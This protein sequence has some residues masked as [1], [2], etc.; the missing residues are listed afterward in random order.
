M[1]FGFTRLDAHGHVARLNALAEQS[2]TLI[3]GLRPV[4]QRISLSCHTPCRIVIGGRD[5]ARA[6]QQLKPSAQTFAL[7][8]VCV[9]IIG[10]G[11]QGRI[12]RGVERGRFR[13]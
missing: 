3:I 10:L 9:S 8:A 6:F 5:C 4:A 13:R 1:A 11:E 12:G 7:G 2:F